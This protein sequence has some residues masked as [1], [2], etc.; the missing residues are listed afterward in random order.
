MKN[1][2]FT[3]EKMSPT[4]RNTK[5]ILQQFQREGCSVVQSDVSIGDIKRTSGIS[6]RELTFVFADSQRVDLR[7]KQSGDI[8]QVVLNGKV[9]PIRNQ[10][11]H[12]KAIAEIAASVKA[13]SE[14]HQK[15]LAQRAAKPPAAMKSAAPKIEQVLTQRREELTES[16]A[17]VERQIEAIRAA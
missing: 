3:F 16:I 11:D 8:F 6:Y 5:R 13:N 10:D 2:L 7:V 14:A 1:I 9:I 4:D 15:K 17:E 12:A